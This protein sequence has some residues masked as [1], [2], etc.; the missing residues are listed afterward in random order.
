MLEIIFPI[1]RD[2]CCNNFGHVWSLLVNTCSIIV[3][4]SDRTHVATLH[5][6]SS[7]R[8]F[9]LTVDHKHVLNR[10]TQASFVED[11]MYEY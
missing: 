4:S 1:L 9:A 5:L 3:Y 8:K 6:F 11:I 7:L 2:N 10:K